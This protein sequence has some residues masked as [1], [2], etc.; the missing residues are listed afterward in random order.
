MSAFTFR[1]GRLL[2]LREALEKERAAEL[3]AARLAEEAKRES[4]EKQQR[5]CEELRS[6]AQCFQGDLSVAGILRNHG[7]L[8]EAALKAA[9][10]EQKALT[11]AE[12]QRTRSQQSFD[13][14]RVERRSLEKLRETAYSDWRYSDNRAEQS[15]I[16]DAALRSNTRSVDS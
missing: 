5:H 13:S 6:G 14:A 2:D 7:I 8:L 15:S 9:E 3:Q 1:L 12:Q 10:L 4:F 16:D 11:E